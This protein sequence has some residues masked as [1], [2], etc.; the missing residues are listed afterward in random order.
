MM[1]YLAGNKPW[2]PSFSSATINLVLLVLIFLSVRKKVGNTDALI[3]FWLLF[4]LIYSLTTV[5]HFAQ[6]FAL[7]GEVPAA[8]LSV[9]GVLTL[10]GSPDRRSSILIGCFAFGLAFMAKML[11]VLGF[12]PV[13]I[14]VISTLFKQ[15]NNLHK[16]F[17]NY[18][19]G[20]IFFLLPFLLFDIYKLSV[21][22][23]DGYIINYNDFF[24]A[25]SL[26]HDLGKQTLTDGFFIFN[27]SAFQRFNLFGEHFGYSLVS[28]FLVALCIGILIHHS[29]K[30]KYVNTIY[31]LLLAGSFLHLFW[32]TCL[33]NGRPRYALI[34]L[35]LYF[36][37]ISCIVLVKVPRIITI[38]LAVIFIFIFQSGF[39]RLT[40]PVANS[41]KYNF[42]YTPYVKNMVKTT[43]FLLN[44]EQNRPFIYTWWASA[45]ELEYSLPA[46]KNFKRIDYLNE[47]DFQRELILVKN[48]KWDNIKFMPA[49]NIYE[50]KPEDI[51]FDAPPFQV[52][53]YRN[54]PT[55]LTVD[56]PVD[57]TKNGNSSDYITF[58]WGLLES[59][60]RWT[61]RT[62]AGLNMK[63]DNKSGNDFIF[64]LLGSGF[65]GNGTIDAQVVNVLFN[66]QTLAQWKVDREQWYEVTIPAQLIND[67]V[68][69][70]IFEISSPM[71]PA[72]CGSG[73]DTRT[74][75]L[76]VKKII[77]VEKRQ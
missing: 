7:L 51:L 43:A 28:I 20:I 48:T 42:E 24:K 32:W 25:L 36:T 76:A 3:F 72:A 73:N 30:D 1:I 13:L 15:K 17:I 29:K 67:S 52:V 77:L 55:I 61:T 66:H 4:F 47:G 75:G 69:S 31:F 16:L 65:L 37:A 6:W 14:W 21:L 10:A 56:Q 49:Y 33:S 54:V 68:N 11:S 57:F 58:G 39:T 5:K 59:N 64:R 9:F 53:R 71:S 41:F 27:A 46:I 44:M 50:S 60:C 40:T 23:I 18:L 63:I 12:I 2:V 70:M 22:G 38:S 26:W 45:A 62:R 74:L 35:F 34:G 19:L 8:L